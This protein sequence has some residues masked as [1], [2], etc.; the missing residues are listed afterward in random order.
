MQALDANTIRE[1]RE[2]L[3]D[4]L[5]ELFAEFIQLVPAELEQIQQC[6]QQGDLTSIEHKVHQIK[7]SAANLG[8]VAFAAGCKELEEGLRSGDITE[9]GSYVEEIHNLFE[10][11]SSEIK[12]LGPAL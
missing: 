5:D 8:V 1:L 6:M 2:M 12:K 9:P 4:E 10:Q 7:G 11:A 3:G